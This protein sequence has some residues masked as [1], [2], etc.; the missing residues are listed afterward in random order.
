M[1]VG[2]FNRDGELD[3]A[4]TNYYANTVGILLGKGDGT[5]QVEVDHPTVSGP[6]SVAVGDRNG[7]RSHAKR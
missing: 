4:V 6:T 2:D 5:F 1:A 3:L 7:R